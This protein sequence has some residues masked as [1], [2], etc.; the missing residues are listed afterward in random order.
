[1]AT[2]NVWSA[3][4][5]T[6][7]TDMGIWGNPDPDTELQRDPAVK[8]KTPQKK[9]INTGKTIDSFKSG[10]TSF[11]RPNL[12]E[13][14]IHPLGGSTENSPMSRKLSLSCHTCSIPGT[15]ISTTENSTHQ[16]AY[17]A[18]A[19]Q[20]LYEDVSM[21]FYVSGDMKEIEVFQNW[22]KLMVNPTNNRVGYHKTYASTN[23]E[24]KNLDQN[25]NKVL[26]TTL[27]EA[28]P[29]TL[30]AVDLTYG[31]V[32]EVM[33]ITVTF[34]YRYYEQV[35]GNKET[36]GENL[37]KNIEKVKVP[38]VAAEISSVLDKT[39]S[40]NSLKGIHRNESNADFM[41][42]MLR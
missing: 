26:T 9:K 21:S 5:S 8:E 11:A 6:G 12:F 36:I 10:M 25:Q 41:E 22:M 18:I 15:T 29:K 27:F 31:S 23:I 3:N 42:R 14:I 35:F 28:Y 39:Q 40:S 4:N 7:S 33:S 13:V 34:T 38:T 20:R 30:A 2:P 1:M 19:Y 37:E 17:R 32:D 16:V 24:I